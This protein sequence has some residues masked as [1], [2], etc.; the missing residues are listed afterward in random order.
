LGDNLPQKPVTPEAV[1]VKAEDL[2]NFEVTGGT[3][4][5]AGLRHNVSVPLQYLNQSLLVPRAAALLNLM[6]Y[7]TTPDTRQAQP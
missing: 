1:Q 6:A 4:P 7:A 3:V 2:L 5:E